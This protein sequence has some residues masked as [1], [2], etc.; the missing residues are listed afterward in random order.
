MSMKKLPI[1]LLLLSLSA[2]IPNAIGAADRDTTPQSPNVLFIS[3][4]DMA[5]YLGCYGYRDMET[6]NIDQLASRA[7]R[8]ERA[9][10]QAPVCNPSRA[11]VITGLRPETIEVYGNWDDW[12]KRVPADHPTLPELFSAHGYETV[13]IGKI[14]HHVGAFKDRPDP[15]AS[16]RMA[17]M[18]DRELAEPEIPDYPLEPVRSEGSFPKELSPDEQTYEYMKQSLRWGPTGLGA[19]EM[20]DGQRVKSAGEFL[21]QDHAKPFLLAVGIHAPHF[22]FRAPREYHDLY[23]GEEIVYPR[24][25]EDD[26]EDLPIQYPLFNTADE[27]TLSLVERSEM[28]AAYKATIS[29]TDYCVGQ[30]LD[31]LEQSPHAENTIIMLWSDHGM[32]LGEHG[33]W[34]KETLFEESTRVALLVRAP[35]ATA[36]GQSTEGI[37]ELVDLYPTLADLCAIP[38]PPQTDGVSFAPLLKNPGQSWKKAAFTTIR[39]KLWSQPQSIRTARYRYSE[40]G[41]PR[42]VE[43]Y[44]LRHDPREIHNLATD[45]AYQEVREQLHE[46]L[47]AGWD[48]SLPDALR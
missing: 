25:P 27:Y 31:A 41:D 43:L 15:E 18:W 10:A 19:D 17:T 42:H 22:P 32:H 5:P 26:L 28:M 40:W 37:V 1:I 20:A 38:V 24:Y 3:I 47:H 16:Q 39:R 8:F 11:S 29:Y 7:V 33:L 23:T 30:L 13:K 14:N 44:D 4:E 46:Q 34:R 2:W 9:Y 35:G 36:A 6:P 21:Q 45:P 48:A 12:R